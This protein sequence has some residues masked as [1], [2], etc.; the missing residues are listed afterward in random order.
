MCRVDRVRVSLGERLWLCLLYAV[1]VFFMH[2]SE[3]LWVASYSLCDAEN[4]RT[5]YMC[6]EKK[7]CCLLNKGELDGAAIHGGMAFEL[8]CS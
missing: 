6:M 4:T 8:H 1:S 7:T 5:V 3:E 2:P